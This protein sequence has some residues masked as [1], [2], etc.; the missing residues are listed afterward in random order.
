MQDEQLLL[1]LK[2]R[3]LESAAEGV[4]IADANQMGIPI[5]YANRAFTVLTGYQ[6]EEVIGRNC[7]FLQGPDTNPEALQRIRNSLANESLCFEEI[8]N[9]RKDNTPFWNRLS[10]TPVKND[11]GQTTHFI[12]IQS[13]ITR[14]RLAEDSLKEANAKLK[15]DLL[16]AAELQQDQ[17]PKKLPDCKKYRFAWRFRPCQEL[18]GDTLNILPLDDRHIAVYVLDVSG[19]GVRAALQSF[20]INHD[21]QPHRGVLNLL[22]PEKVLDWLNIK[23]S[24]VLQIGMFFTISYG[25]LDTHTGKFT[26]S[27]AG[28]PGPILTHKDHAPQIIESPSYPIGINPKAEYTLKTIQLQAGEKLIMFTDGVLEAI[29][30]Q[31]KAFGQTGLLETLFRNRELN[32]DEMLEMIMKSLDNWVNHANLKDDVSLVGFESV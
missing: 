14:R 22:S 11:Q 8:L 16:A 9:Y 12:G 15:R 27:S 7:R 29:D 23:Y 20:S 1:L 28:H 24:Q 2:E 3:A 25:I 26:F 32:I 18:A 30:M 10:I 6:P 4:V 5:I 19:H 31:G 21:L 17:L 13:D